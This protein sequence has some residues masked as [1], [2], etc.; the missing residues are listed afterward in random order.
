MIDYGELGPEAVFQRFHELQQYRLVLR[1]QDEPVI[2]GIL[3]V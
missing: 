2:G 1:Q 3:D